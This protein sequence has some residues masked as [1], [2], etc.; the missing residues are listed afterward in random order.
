MSKGDRPASNIDLPNWAGYI[1]ATWGILE[2]V[3]MVLAA[4]DSLGKS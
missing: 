4:L 3:R 1:L 2:R